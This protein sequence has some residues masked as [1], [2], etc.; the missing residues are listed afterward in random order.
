MLTDGV[1][2]PSTS[3]YSSPVLLIKKKDCSWRFCVDYRALNTITVRD[4]FPILTANKL[5]DELTDA[6]IFSKLDLR[7]RYHQ[8]RIHPPDIEKT[9]FQTSDGH[10]EFVVMPFR[11]S[12]PPSPSRH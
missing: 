5:F 11:L 9:A 3:P 10:F 6:T 8:I 4:R 2:R 1:I 7:A 12:D